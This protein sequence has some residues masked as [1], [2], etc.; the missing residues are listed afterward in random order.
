MKRR[1]HARI[2]ISARPKPQLFWLLVSLSFIGLVI[3]RA[4]F[5]LPVWFDEI[6]A[7][8]FLFGLPFLI[9]IFA[10]R[11]NAAA[12]GMSPRRF[13]LGAYLGLALGGC[14]GFVAMVASAL[15]T[16]GQILIPNLFFASDF[17]WIF[18]LALATAWWESL[19]FY[20]FILNV[21]NVIRKN[22]WEASLV[23][24]GLF[25]IFHAPILLIRGGL[26]GAVVP[27]ILLGM[28]AFGQAVLYLRFRSLIAMVVSHAFWGMALLVYTLK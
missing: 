27:L 23:A 5:Q 19:F 13:W 26:T 1:T 24:T 17:W 10:N 21:I 16:G 8:A 28:F 20:G 4:F 7:K 18:F 14:F 12:V 9:Y 2:Q 3:Y 15:K 22:E 11:Q 6:V 25:L